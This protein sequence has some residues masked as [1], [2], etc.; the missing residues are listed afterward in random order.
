ML[1]G[2]SKIIVKPGVKVITIEPSADALSVEEVVKL[3]SMAFEQVCALKEVQRLGIYFFV[4]TRPATFVETI[5]P[6]KEALSMEGSTQNL[7][8]EFVNH[9]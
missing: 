3:F 6:A 4:Q 8:R 9:L 2:C 7:N 1:C 5:R